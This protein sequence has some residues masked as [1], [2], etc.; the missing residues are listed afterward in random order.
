[1]ET[2]IKANTMK[3]NLVEKVNITG[4]TALHTKDS[5][6]MA[7]AMVRECGGQPVI[8]AISTMGSI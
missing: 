7:D 8:L 4:A 1:M 5:S 2:N 6:S 3:I